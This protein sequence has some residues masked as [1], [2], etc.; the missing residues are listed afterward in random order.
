[1]MGG[2]VMSSMV[3]H[4]LEC[5]TLTHGDRAGHPIPAHGPFEKITAN[6]NAI[7]HHARAD[8]VRVVSAFI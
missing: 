3:D 6:Y 5:L 8:F 2:K 4:Q 7:G 1:M